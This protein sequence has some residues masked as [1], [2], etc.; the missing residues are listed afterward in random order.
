M[1]F[2]G[3]SNLISYNFV[4]LSQS[5]HRIVAF[6]ASY[7]QPCKVVTSHLK[8]I[9][10]GMKILHGIKFYGFT[11][12]DTTV[13][14]KSINFYSINNVMSLLKIRCG[15]WPTMTPDL[16]KGTAYGSEIFPSSLLQLNSSFTTGVQINTA[17]QFKIIV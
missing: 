3:F 13:K 16:L 7:S 5:Y 8:V 12:G 14:L 10:Y 4:R 2:L 11:V 17:F 9:P 15:T 1:N 6:S